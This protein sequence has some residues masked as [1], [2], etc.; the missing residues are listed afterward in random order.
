[1]KKLVTIL[2]VLAF[3]VLVGLTQA[4]VNSAYAKGLS[5]SSSQ[6]QP[7]Q[8]GQAMPGAQHSQAQTFAGTIAK[9]NGQYVLQSGGQS[10]ALDNQA[11]AK[12][13]EGKTVQVTGTLDS[14]SNTIHVE[15]ITSQ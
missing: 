15:K 4:G 11:E 7:G 6:N 13:F 3:A 9:A 10:Y 5:A 2:S 8:S 1:M 12:K 14:S